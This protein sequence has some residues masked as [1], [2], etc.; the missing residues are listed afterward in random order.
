[1]RGHGFTPTRPEGRARPA[2]RA[3]RRRRHRRPRVPSHHEQ[4]SG[5]WEEIWQQPGDRSRLTRHLTATRTQ[6]VEA[7]P[8]YP[9]L[10]YN[11]SHIRTGSAG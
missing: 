1:V 7:S 4:A 10:T 11:S 9:P 3:R 5:R 6:T 2:R 8:G